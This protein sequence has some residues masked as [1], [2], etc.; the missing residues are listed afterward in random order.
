M[1]QQTE[2]Y[3]FRSLRMKKFSFLLTGISFLLLGT[4]LSVDAQGP[5]SPPITYP[6]APVATPG[7]GFTPTPSTPTPTP[8]PT[9]VANPPVIDNANALP[10]TVTGPGTTPAPTPVAGTTPAPTPTPGLPVQPTAEQ[11]RAQGSAVSQLRRLIRDVQSNTDSVKAV[12]NFGA[13]LYLI[14]DEAF[15]QDWRKPETPTIAPVQLAVRGQPLYTAVIF[16]GE[17]RDNKGLANV[18]YDL[19]VHRPDGSVYAERK[20]MIGWQNLAPDERELQL[21]RNYLA[22]NIAP[23]DPAGIYAVDAVIHDNI[24]RVELPLKQTFVVR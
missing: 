6:N 3:L 24:G 21:G 4:F 17:A 7:P 20:P 10:S 2:A 1:I 18:T 22:I 8:R 11:S 14:A 15:F 13:Q 12:G 19:T 16:Y 9:T 23:N 5:S